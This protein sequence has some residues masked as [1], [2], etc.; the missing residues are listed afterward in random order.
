MGFYPGQ[1]APKGEGDDAMSPEQKKAKLDKLSDAHDKALLALHTYDNGTPLPPGCRQ[2]DPNTDEGRAELATLGITKDDLSP[3]GSS[4]HAELFVKDGQYVLAFR[5]TRPS[6]VGDLE[7]DAEQ[8]AGFDAEAYDKAIDLAKNLNR[9]TDGDLSFTGHSLGGGLASA[10]AV[11]TGLP[12]TTF[13]AAGLDT[14]SIK[15]QSSTPPQVDACYV[16]GE[17]LSAIQDNRLAVIP[18]AVA[19]LQAV[20]YVGEAV[21]G[22]VSVRKRKAI[23]YWRRPMAPAFRF[24]P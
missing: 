4:M 22:M 10:A 1:F 19:A 16:R 23:R 3:P 14:A 2:I 17:P 24:R 21:A 12:A 5:G 13:N 18:G 11:V 15:D 20:P 9:T 6:E 8:G 7:N